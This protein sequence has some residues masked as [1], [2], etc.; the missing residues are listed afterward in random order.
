VR[1]ILYEAL[2]VT[3]FAGMIGLAAML[4]SATS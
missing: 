2:N 1:R 3:A 4:W